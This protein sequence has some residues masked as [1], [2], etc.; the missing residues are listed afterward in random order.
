MAKWLSGVY[1]PH[2]AVI[3][4]LVNDISG[5][6]VH[7]VGAVTSYSWGNIQVPARSAQ[8]ISLFV[9]N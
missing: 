1:V 4:T 6:L 7:M 2:V 5:Y 9:T 3:M 8:A